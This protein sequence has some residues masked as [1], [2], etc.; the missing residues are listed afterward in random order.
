MS[1]CPKCRGD[2]AQGDQF[3]S[4]CGFA[5]TTKLLG[6][7]IIIVTTPTVPGHRIKKVMGIVTG[8][9]AR[10]RG[11]GGKF[12]AGIQSMLGGEVSAFT[13]EIEKARRE[14]MKRMTDKAKKLS[15]NAV[16]GLDIETSDVLQGT[17]LISATGTAV[18]IEPG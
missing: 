7:G 6:S 9:T 14:A 1:F 12:V 13:S 5:I 18:I 8:L 16:I 15:A 11:M 3:C 4:R 10:T 2:V 17:I